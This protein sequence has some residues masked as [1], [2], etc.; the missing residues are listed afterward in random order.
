MLYV[1]VSLKLC[2]LTLFMQI[3][4]DLTVNSP[5]FTGTGESKESQSISQGKKGPVRRR[6]SLRLNLIMTNNFL[7]TGD[8]QN[9]SVWSDLNITG[10]RETVVIMND[11]FSLLKVE[12]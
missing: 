9:C 2:F 11:Y 7:A 6:G 4:K 8:K 3:E 5:V 10:T 12:L 1:G